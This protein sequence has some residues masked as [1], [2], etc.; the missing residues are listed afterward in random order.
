MHQVNEL[1]KTN[2]ERKFIQAQKRANGQSGQATA[3]R[4]A[5]ETPSAQL[6][7]ASDRPSSR[8]LTGAAAPQNT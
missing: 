3:A 5:V 2:Q 4:R 6:C 1:H 8:S 7:S